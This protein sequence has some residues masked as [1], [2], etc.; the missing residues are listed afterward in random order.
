LGRRSA[1]AKLAIVPKTRAVLV[2][3]A[4]LSACSRSTPPAEGLG[5]ASAP[6]LADSS[7]ANPAAPPAFGPLAEPPRVERTADGI[8]IL[9]A[10]PPPSESAGS[11]RWLRDAARTLQWTSSEASDG[12]RVYFAVS[13][14]A[15]DIVVRDGVVQE[16]VL[17][18]LGVS[19]GGCG[20]ARDGELLLS[21]VVDSDDMVNTVTLDGRTGTRSSEMKPRRVQMV[22]RIRA[23]GA[24][25]KTLLPPTIPTDDRCRAWLGPKDSYALATSTLVNWDGKQHTI[26]RELYA[27][28][29][30][31]G[32]PT[33]PRYCFRYCKQ[34][35][36]AANP[37]ATKKLSQ[38]CGQSAAWIAYQDWVGGACRGRAV[39][40][41]PS[42][43]LEVL[44]G[45]PSSK[46]LNGSHDAVF[47]ERGDMV[48]ALDYRFASYLVWPL[49]AKAHSPV[50]RLDASD[51]LAK[52][53]PTMIVRGIGG[54]V[55]E[56]NT[57][58]VVV[59]KHVG[60]GTGG[61]TYGY[62]G[63]SRSAEAH[64]A[65]VDRARAVLGAGDLVVVHEAVVDRQCGAYLRSPIGHENMQIHDFS[66]PKLPA[67]SAKAV[68]RPARCTPLRSVSALPANPDLLLAIAEDGQL[69]G[70]WLPPPLPLPHGSH[71][72]KPLDKG[73][74][75][76]SPR[77]GTGWLSVG[78]VD[79]VEG[80]DGVPAPGADTAIADG[81]WQAGGAAVLHVGKT[82]ILFTP[83]G[84]LTLP[85]GTKPMAVGTAGTLAAW[86]AKGH[87]LVVCAVKGCRLLDPG[88]HGDIV[89]VVPRSLNDLI[90]GYADGR[91]GVYLTPEQGGSAIQAHPLE[92]A[93]EELLEKRPK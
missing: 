77:A 72:G 39:R 41:G 21:G 42:G 13:E 10:K 68:T 75:A 19:E 65:Q 84:A 25:E 34:A 88:D 59:G 80:I 44:D 73:P 60:Y 67:L 23:N 7:A 43:A 40:L 55:P 93:L 91:V 74:I 69:L 50:R 36:E 46:M 18:S 62:H 2:C 9:K 17:R 51:V 70:A 33:S 92:D 30:T 54:T 26:A 90:L 16:G 79:R 20:A 15:D 32:S 12:A 58:A 61:G 86:G 3:L 56:S 14:K 45:L 4:A 63:I 29:M 35:E 57:Y 6:P 1:A 76:Q 5:S 24:I 47:T 87:E 49:G 11:V 37:P 22:A 82:A 71:F 81:S 28:R 27:G 64:Q 83:N 48:I 85:P 8:V 52:A 31:L 66:P 53:S 78:R 38:A 89:A